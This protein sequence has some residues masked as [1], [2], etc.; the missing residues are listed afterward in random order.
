MIILFL[1]PRLEE[2]IKKNK[3]ITTTAGFEPARAEPKRFL[4]FRLNHSAKLPCYYEKFRRVNQ[5]HRD[6]KSGEGEPPF[7]GALGFYLCWDLPPS[8]SGC[9]KRQGCTHMEITSYKTGKGY[10]ANANA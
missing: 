3:K 10:V 5:S 9:C 8:P 4:I 2:I 1:P 6:G 7:P